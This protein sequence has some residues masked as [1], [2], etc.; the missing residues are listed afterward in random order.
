MELGLDLELVCNLALKYVKDL[1]RQRGRKGSEYILIYEKGNPD[2]FDDWPFA[3]EPHQVFWA[4]C[5][6]ECFPIFQH[7]RPR[8]IGMCGL[9]YPYCPPPSYLHPKGPAAT[10]PL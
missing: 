4:Y 8:N 5:F 9:L 3:Q 2:S 10:V 6:P 1:K 7:H